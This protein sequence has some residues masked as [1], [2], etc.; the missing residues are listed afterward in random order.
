LAIVN[1]EA[2]NEKKEQHRE[3]A[4]TQDKGNDPAGTSTQTER[5]TVPCEKYDRMAEHHVERSNTSKSVK[6][7]EGP[8]SLITQ[9]ETG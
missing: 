9:R 5:R 2:A 3:V 7:N 4:V 8:T 1:A 6:E